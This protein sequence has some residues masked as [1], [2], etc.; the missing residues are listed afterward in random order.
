MR[1]STKKVFIQ[2]A[3]VTKKL[4]I[5]SLRLRNHM[6]KAIRRIQFFMIALNTAITILMVKTQPP[7]IC[8]STTSAFTTV[9]L[10]QFKSDSLSLLSRPLHLCLDRATARSSGVRSGEMTRFF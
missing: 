10:Y 2:V 9:S 3:V 8:D 5:V 4:E 6:I 1:T 7:V